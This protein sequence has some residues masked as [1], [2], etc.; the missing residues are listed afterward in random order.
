MLLHLLHLLQPLNISYFLLLKRVYS[1][2]IILL[3]RRSIIYITKLDFLTTFK[4]AYYKTFIVESIKK[5]FRGARLILHNLNTIV[6]RL[7]IRLYIPN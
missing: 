2:K 6:L 3:A 5:A 4:T 7:N 1:T